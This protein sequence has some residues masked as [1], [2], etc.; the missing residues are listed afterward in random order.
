[1]RDKRSPKKIPQPKAQ[2]QGP[3]NPQYDH[4]QCTWHYPYHTVPSATT[5]PR[6][7]ACTTPP[8][9]PAAATPPVGSPKC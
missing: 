1:M 6:G 9:T 5:C 2:Q 8:A 3:T 7:V 4:D